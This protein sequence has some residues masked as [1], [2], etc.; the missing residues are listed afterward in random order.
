MGAIHLV[1]HKP[2]CEDDKGCIQE[3]SS[4]CQDSL[5]GQLGP[6]TYLGNLKAD[7]KNKTCENWVA[8]MQSKSGVEIRLLGLL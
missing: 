6:D 7:S 1:S 4:L 5:D 8:L 2:L 3:V